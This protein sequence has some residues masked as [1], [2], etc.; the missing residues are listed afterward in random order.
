MLWHEGDLKVHDPSINFTLSML[1]SNDCSQCLV[2][3]HLQH[4]TKVKRYKDASMVWYSMLGF[5]IRL[6]MHTG[7]GLVRKAS[8]DSVS[9]YRLVLSVITSHPASSDVMCRWLSN[10]CLVINK[11]K[12]RW[13]GRIECKDDAGLSS[14]VERWRMIDADWINAT[15]RH[16]MV[17]SWRMLKVLS[18]FKDD[19]WIWN[20]WKHPLKFT[21]D[22]FSR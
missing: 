13:F 19:A 16:S 18:S 5:N 10:A 20:K 15:E 1:E 6:D 7:C 12:L 11:A 3:N 2:S 8:C 17:V 14:I 22:V 9:S 4:I 21:L